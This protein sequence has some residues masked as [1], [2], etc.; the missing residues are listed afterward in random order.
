MPRQPTVFLA[1]DM[2]GTVGYV[3]WPRPA[4]AGTPP[5]EPAERR[6]QLL[7]EVNAAIDGAMAGGAARVIVSDAHWSKKNL[8]PAALAGGAGLVRGGPRPYLWMTGV[9]KADLVFLVG[10]HAAAGTGGAVLPHTIDPRVHGLYINGQEA[11][12]ALLSTLAAGYHGVP[13]ALVSGD[14]ALVDEVRTFLPQVAAVAVKEAV[15][16]GCALGLHPEE[17]ASRLAAAA[18]AA[19]GRARELPVLRP[20]EPVDLEMILSE[21]H[22]CDALRLFPDVTAKGGRTIACRA[23]WPRIMALLSLFAGWIR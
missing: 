15:L 3:A 8:D 17:A 23:A 19:V 2:E 1:A 20:R 22:W 12:E 14:Q 21:P 6:E 9:E 10:F 18:R 16:S 4:A 5:P 13:V 11:G 7:R